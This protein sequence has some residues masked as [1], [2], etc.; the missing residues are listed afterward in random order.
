MAAGVE[1]R[2]RAKAM[3]TRTA[4]RP[5]GPGP[6]WQR[7][8]LP[9]LFHLL[10]SFLSMAASLSLSLGLASWEDSK[11]E[12]GAVECAREGRKDRGLSLVTRVSAFN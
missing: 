11:E 2:K 4:R 10:A 5:A 7:V 1:E 3:A 9:F 6:P 12:R 8:L